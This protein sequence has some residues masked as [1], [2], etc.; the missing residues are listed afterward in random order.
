MKRIFKFLMLA[1]IAVAAL[2]LSSCGDDSNVPDGMKLAGGGEE[3]GY[4]FYVPEEWVVSSYGDFA[5]SY[6]SA[7]NATSVTFG[8]ARMPES[9]ADGFTQDKVRAYFNDEMSKI[10][11]MSSMTLSTNGEE[12]SFGNE[13]NAY[14]FIYTYDYPRE[15]GT[16]INYGAM[17]ILIVRG[18]R[19]Y[20][21]QYN[22]QRSVP[23]YSTDG[24]THYDLYLDKVNDIIQAFKFTGD[25][26]APAPSEAGSSGELVLVSDSEIC[27]FDFYAPSDS[28]VVT[29]SSLVQVDLGA[30]A[31]V[32][33]SELILDSL[34]DSSTF[35]INEYWEGLKANFEKTYGTVT[36]LTEYNS[37]GKD[38]NGKDVY[39]NLR[40]DI[41][42]A[43]GG[44]YYEYEY[45][46]GDTEYRQ[47]MVIV[48]ISTTFSYKYYVYTYT[49]PKAEY[50]SELCN[51]LL[52]KTEFK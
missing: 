52:L 7:V 10:D 51:T 27:G 46:Y 25:V 36:V 13:K 21:F 50:N 30:G 49:A 17:Q 38:E 43:D 22:S 32:S 33:V 47:Y 45:K 3:Y 23:S 9:G 19:L 35:G 11:Y 37:I 41:N 40:D 15:D 44:R 12:C 29:S 28:R 42:G 18:S 34:P 24:K 48:G 14:K 39:P 31:S 5:C 20:I 26:T 1:A 4:Y 16:V 2:G 6:I 8:E